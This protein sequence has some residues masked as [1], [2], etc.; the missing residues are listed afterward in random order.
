A[1]NGMLA[2]NLIV[3]QHNIIRSPALCLSG[4][5]DPGLRLVQLAFE[6]LIAN[7][8]IY[9]YLCTQI[10]ICNPDPL[11]ILPLYCSKASYNLSADSRPGCLAAWRGTSRISRPLPHSDSDC[12]T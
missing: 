11:S 2:G 10:H 7:S 3:G 8:R 6:S 4:P 12:D 5:S 9:H 1:N